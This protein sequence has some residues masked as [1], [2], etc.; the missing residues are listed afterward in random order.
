[1]TEPPFIGVL[2]VQ[3]AFA[4]HERMLRRVG[5]GVRRVRTVEGLAGCD[6]LVIPGGE[7]T[8]LGLVAGE[9]GLVAAVRDRIAGGMPAFGTCAGLIMLATATTSDAQPLIGAMD[10]TV[11]RNAWGRQRASF[12]AELDMPVIGDPP[13]TGVFIRAPW[14]ESHGPRVEVLA[15]WDG[16]AVAAR[17]GNMLVTAFHPELTDDVRVHGLFIEMVGEH[18]DPTGMDRV[19]GGASRGR[20]Q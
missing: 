7:S 11:R 18:R 15:E 14:I 1:M 17:E 6:A 19:V 5:A 4:E 3:G 8:T 13:I 9:S 12:E 2:A 10:L 20:A 16:H